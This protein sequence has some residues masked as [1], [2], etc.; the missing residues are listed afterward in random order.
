MSVPSGESKSK[1]KSCRQWP[2]PES[3]WEEVF[4]SDWSEMY[5]SEPRN[6]SEFHFTLS[7][8]NS[9]YYSLCRLCVLK[10]QPIA[11]SETVGGVVHSKTRGL[12]FKPSHRHSLQKRKCRYCGNGCG[13]DGRAAAS[14]PRGLRFKS[15]RGQNFKQNIG[16]LLT[17]ENMKITK[18]RVEMAHLEHGIK[19][20]WP[21]FEEIYS[22]DDFI[23]LKP[24]PPYFTPS[25]HFSK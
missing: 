13:S 16:L 12:R 14:K 17:I 8:G 18:K 24:L 19:R 5:L 10:R 2:K 4:T 11:I 20:N 23:F 7:N 25:L 15:S 1:A 9:C 21:H 6:L 3:T 22:S